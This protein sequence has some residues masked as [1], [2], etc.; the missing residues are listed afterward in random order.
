MLHLGG[1]PFDVRPRP[2]ITAVETDV[3][4]RLHCG[5]SDG[6]PGSPPFR[7]E[8][9]TA[10]P[11]HSDDAGLYPRFAPALVRPCGD[12]V[13][14]SHGDFT[15]EVDAV[16]ARGTLFRTSG[17]SFPLEATLRVALTCRLPLAGGLP[18]H[19]AALAIRGRAIVFF[20][21][22]GAGK[23]TLSSLSPYPVLTDEMVALT[24]RSEKFVAGPSGFW[25][26]LEGRRIRPGR[27]PLAAL[28]HLEKGP[29]TVIAPLARPTAYRRLL[30]VTLVPGVPRL[31][32]SVTAVLARL[33]EEVDVFR[34]EWSPAA[35]PWGELESL[36]RRTG[37]RRG[38][39]ARQ[40]GFRGGRD[41]SADRGAP[42]G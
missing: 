12:L 1:I 32:H 16:A 41:S 22:S 7:L 4:R 38:R 5:G 14:L 10:A 34:M 24:R 26:T 36:L 9:A 28:V 30:S 18:L 39:S 27:L 20:G 17:G 29:R 40:P 19:A 15:A 31:W 8:I 37:G 42:R 25:G 13:R 2:A 6:P 3:L 33:V 23:S 35:P 11:W 21:R